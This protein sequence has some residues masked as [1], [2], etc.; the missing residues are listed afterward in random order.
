MKTTPIF[1]GPKSNPPHAQS[2]WFTVRNEGAESS[3]PVEILIYDQIGKD[4]FS[5]DGIAAKDFDAALKAI[6]KDQEVLLRI[7]SPGGNVWDGFAIYQMIRARGNVV[8]QCDGI[9]ASIASIIMLAGDRRIM[10]KASMMMMH[11]ALCGCEGNADDMR[12]AADKLDKHDKVLASIYAER[13]GITSDEALSMMAA[14]TWMT[15]EE[16][17]ARGF[18]TECT[19][20]EAILNSFDL[21]GF[22][23]V[24]ASIAAQVKN[25]AKSAASKPTKIMNR[26]KII[27]Q[28]KNLGVKVNNAATDEE[29]VAQL[30]AVIAE[31]KARSEGDETENEE[32]EEKPDEKKADEAATN[33]L[34]AD[35]TNLRKDIQNLQKVKADERRAFVTQKVENLIADGKVLASEKEISIEQA[36]TNEKL[37]DTW[38]KREVMKPGAEPLNHV[39]MTG[40]A[41]PDDVLKG[42][43]NTNKPIQAMF[44]GHTVS[45]LEIK[46]AALARAR[47]LNTHGK[48]LGVVLNA[49]TVDAGLK[50]QVILNDIMRAYK[51][52]IIALNA[53]STVFANVPL[54]GTAKINVPYYALHTV[55]STDWNAANGYVFN[56]N[57]ATAMKEITIDKRKYQPFDF[58]S[59][60]FRRQPFFNVQQQAALRAEQLG[61]DVWTDVMSVFTAAN[62]G[63]IV[64]TEPA[65]AFDTDD[66]VDIGVICDQA[67]WPEA[68]RTMLLDSAYA[69]NVLKDLQ[70]VALQGGND[71][72]LRTGA[73][74][75]ISEF[76]IF[77]CPRIPT[78]SANIVGMAVHPSAVLVATSPI[79]PAP[80]VLKNLVAYDVVTDPE[81]SISF[82]YRYWGTPQ[83]D[84]DYETIEANYGYAA[85]EAAGAKLIAS[86]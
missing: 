21:S 23:R 31:L 17:E 68:M 77:K 62:F 83:T 71:Q 67:D 69:G 55:S 3:D 7:N 38:S 14:T 73:I 37:L 58:S 66:I 43:A 28:L 18:C 59:E 70:K 79:Q 27:A 39:E 34:K 51:R 19:E 13:T 32:T 1:N 26:E 40:D 33:R 76:E 80:G 85:G 6:P 15:G 78:N 24:P 41:A 8:T 49:N 63:A 48:K 54:L 86:A 82:E 42:I 12:E 84:K 5:D 36:I 25:A 44:K 9:A 20:E 64:K 16:C 46:D 30:E 74:G 60:E 81:T 52:R 2:K 53:F 10:P 61:I 45:N 75:R 35:V 65:A 57:S 56:G 50:R 22:E 47:I 29:L 72:M 11:K 4:W